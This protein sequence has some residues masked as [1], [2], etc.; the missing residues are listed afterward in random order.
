MAFIDE[1]RKMAVDGQEQRKALA[2]QALKK[3]ILRAAQSGRKRVALTEIDFLDQNTAQFVLGA[4]QEL[5]KQGGF[6]LTNIAIPKR[7]DPIW[8]RPLSR[9]FDK[10][11]EPYVYYVL[12]W[13]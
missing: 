5:E 9:L 4:A 7:P 12:E 3:A 1:V 2:E 13:D 11:E 8:F 10:A 6:R